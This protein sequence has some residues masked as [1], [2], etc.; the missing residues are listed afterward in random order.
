MSQPQKNIHP[1]GI[2]TRVRTGLFSAVLLLDASFSLF[3]MCV[4]GLLSEDHRMIMITGAGGLAGVLVSFL[5]MRRSMTGGIR[6]PVTRLQRRIMLRT[7]IFAGML[8]SLWLIQYSRFPQSRGGL[9][10]GQYIY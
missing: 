8:C 7:V 4:L 3:G 10:L 1:I 5:I 9:S 2:M 6:I